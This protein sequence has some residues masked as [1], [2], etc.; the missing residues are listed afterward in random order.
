MGEQITAIPIK[1]SINCRGK[2]IDLSTPRV[3]GILN[4]TPD[5]F[6]DGG[7]YNTA[8]ELLRKAEEHL[9]A[10][11]DILD[12][13]AIS[14]RPNALEISEEEEHQRLLPAI[15]FIRNAF[16][17]AI[18]SVDTY[19]AS[20]AQRAVELGAD[21]IN[22]ISGGSMDNDM[23]ETIAKLQV[24]YVLM[25]INGTPQTMQQQTKYDDLTLDIYDWILKRVH[26]LEVLGVHDVIIDPGFGFAKTIDQNFELL[27]AL[28]R[29][30]M[31]GRPVL[32]GV[33]RKS[34][35]YKTLKIN[36]NE[37]LNG[38]TYMHAL[39]LQKGVNILRAHD[40]KEA[41]ECV[42]LHK[43]LQSNSKK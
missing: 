2:L 12:L 8:P 27:S 11:A 19:R 37:A 17:E 13:G 35:I 7:H 24:P 31:A 30:K 25:H 40:V 28:D 6:Y 26:Q 42:E 9:T 4:V 41:V 33:S 32:A 39:A 36:P 38:T 14:T 20:T 23:F 3:M 22:D 18:L 16:P 10:G 29:F 1:Q 34:F 5:S 43:R 15:E 21:I